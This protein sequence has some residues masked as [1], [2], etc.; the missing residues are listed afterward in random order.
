VQQHARQAE[1]AV[2]GVTTACIADRLVGSIPSACWATARTMTSVDPAREVFDVAV[3]R[4]RQGVG[5]AQDLV[6]GLVDQVQLERRMIVEEMVPMLVDRAA[7]Q[8][9]LG[10]TGPTVSSQRSSRSGRWPKLTA[11]IVTG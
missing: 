4:E 7:V 8:Q 9:E 3:P 11:R 10:Q 6:G 5:H 2:P 1:A